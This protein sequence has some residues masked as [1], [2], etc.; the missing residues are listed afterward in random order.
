MQLSLS[1]NGH[2]PLEDGHSNDQINGEACNEGVIEG[3]EC[4][5]QINGGGDGN[6]FLKGQDGNTSCG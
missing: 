4:D 5:D 1:Y 3:S 6:K 2:T